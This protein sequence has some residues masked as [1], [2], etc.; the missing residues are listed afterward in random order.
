MTPE[1]GKFTN[2]ANTYGIPY[3]IETCTNLGIDCVDFTPDISEWM[4]ADSKRVP[5]ESNFTKEGTAFMTGQLSSVVEKYDGYSSP[6]T[7]PGQKPETFGDLTTKEDD[8]LDGD[9]NIPYRLTVNSQGLRMNH[10][11]TFPKHK[12]TILFLGD[13]RIFNPY[14]DN[15]YII[16]ELLQRKYPD[17]EIINA[18]NMRYTMEDYYTLYVEKA[19]YTEPDVVIVCTNGGDILDNYFSQRNKYSRSGRSYKPTE[20][21]QKFYQ[22]LPK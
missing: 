21:E 12:Q 19:R 17:K 5:V 15:E 13:S 8:I 14:V 11:L 7:H 20:L 22:Q 18:G 1:V 10:N 4:E 3:I 6:V 9:K 16:T 2:A